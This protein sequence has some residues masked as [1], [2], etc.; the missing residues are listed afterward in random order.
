VRAISD[1]EKEEQRNQPEKPLL[2][3]RAEAG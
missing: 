3:D 1:D 2:H